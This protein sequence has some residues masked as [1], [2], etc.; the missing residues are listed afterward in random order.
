MK[1]PILNQSGKVKGFT[2]DIGNRVIIED[3]QGKLLGFY[4]KNHDRTYNRSG[5]IMGKGNQIMI[6]LE[7]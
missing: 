2:N 5:A 6:L 4:E 7:N 3:E 1:Q